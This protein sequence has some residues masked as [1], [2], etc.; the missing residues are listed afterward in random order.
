MLISAA[1]LSQNAVAA[2]S[3][4]AGIPTGQARPGLRLAENKGAAAVTDVNAALEALIKEDE[5]KKSQ[6]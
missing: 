4:A 2:S 1:F 3:E 5:E 6:G